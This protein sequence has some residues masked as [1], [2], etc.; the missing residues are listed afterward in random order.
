[1]SSAASVYATLLPMFRELECKLHPWWWPKGG[2]RRLDDWGLAAE[3]VAE[4]GYD[5]QAI[6]DSLR[7]GPQPGYVPDMDY[8]G[9]PGAVAARPDERGLVWI[10][11]SRPSNSSFPNRSGTTT[12]LYNILRQAEFM[13]RAHITDFIKFRG[14]GPDSRADDKLD[15]KLKDGRTLR[16][17]SLDCLRSEWQLLPP[18]VVLVA[19][20]KAQTW[21]SE[22]LKVL[23]S[24]N[25]S[26]RRFLDDLRS[27]MRPV[28]SWMASIPQSVIAADWKLKVQPNADK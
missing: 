27:K 25:L 1:M 26:E 18:C 19:G 6:F 10:L 12:R 9:F 28:T 21:L 13:D 22:W 24:K 8:P 3:D 4:A 14:P 16:E 20:G 2:G 7:I 23:S 17:V 5:P 15:F 11:S